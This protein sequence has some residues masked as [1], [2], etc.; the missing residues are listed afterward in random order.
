MTRSRIV[1]M[2]LGQWD[3]LGVELKGKEEQQLEKEIS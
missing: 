3:T 1:G 2:E